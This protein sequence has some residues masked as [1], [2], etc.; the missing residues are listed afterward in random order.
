MSEE[1]NLAK[2]D[3][4]EEG[5][6]GDNGPAPVRYSFQILSHR[7]ITCIHFIFMNKLKFINFDPSMFLIYNAYYF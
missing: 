1:E 5:D 6:D 4:G 7:L 2:V 3:A